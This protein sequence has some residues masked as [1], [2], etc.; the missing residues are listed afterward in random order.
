MIKISEEEFE[1]KIKDLI[2]GKF[3][4][5]DLVQEMQTDIRTLNKRII[6]EIGVNNPDLYIEFIKKFPYKQKER[7][8]I[9]YEALVIEMVKN[10]TYSVDAAIKYDVGIRTIQRKV[11]A[12]EK[13]NPYL[14]GIYREVKQLNKNNMPISEELQEKID[15]LVARSVKISE[16]NSTRRE[17]LEEIE[18]IFNNR[19]QYVSKIE[20]AESM[21]MSKHRIYKSLNELY[22][23]RIENN[24][25][26]M[27][28]TLRERVKVDVVPSVSIA[29]EKNSNEEQIQKEGEEK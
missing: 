15:Q 24:Y 7:D 5:I 13:E 28:E 20:A 4:R 29:V 22:R 18:R 16:V 19:C 26:R 9:D 21:G 14:I 10:R 17:Q 8:D 1:E 6:E 23:M 12:L 11:N 25:T 27:E 3:S 2:A